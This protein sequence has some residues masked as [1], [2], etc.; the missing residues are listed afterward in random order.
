MLIALATLLSVAFGQGQNDFIV[1]NQTLLAPNQLSWG[2]GTTVGSPSV[3][4]H[5]PFDTQANIMM[6]VYETQIEGPS[7]VCPAGRWGIGLAYKANGSNTN[8]LN[9]AGPIVIPTA[10][11]Y[12]S[13]V[14][15]HPTIV[16]LNNVG[17]VGGQTW[18]VYFK[19]EQE[20][21]V[22]DKACE[23]YTG[24]GRLVIA[25]QGNS[26]ST[27]TYSLLGPD[28]TPV[29]TEVAQDMGYPKAAFVDGKYRIAFG[30]FP[31]V[32]LASSALSND[33]TVPATPVVTA[34]TPQAWGDDELLS[35]SILCEGDSVLKMF[36]VGRSWDVSPSI[37]TDAS[38]GMLEST[39]PGNDFATYTEG[40]PLPYLS[41]LAGDPEPRHVHV[42]SSATYTEYAMYFSS[43]NG[44]GGNEIRYA[45]TE[46][47]RWRQTDSRRCP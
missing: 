31:D 3:V 25:Y 38:V 41:S 4:V 28:V 36:P 37:L 20:C 32:Y 5:Q 43:P 8:A 46:G 9:D 39:D 6:M 7:A 30:Q 21:A 29:L 45:D 10:G 35:P 17:I 24:L 34:G 27:Y 40:V 33:F 1:R 44:Y 15:A 22:G 26:G 19:A 14:A 12:Y 18:I 11:S 42:A 13:C 23:R 47:F 2:L 16:S